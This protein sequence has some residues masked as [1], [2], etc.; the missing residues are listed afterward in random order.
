MSKRNPDNN[1]V[2]QA[3]LDLADAGMGTLSVSQAIAKLSNDQKLRRDLGTR[4]NQ[5]GYAADKVTYTQLTIDFS[6]MGIS[7]AALKVL[8]FLGLYC[9]Q[10]GY[11]SCRQSVIARATKIS[12]KTVWSALQELQK[13]AFIR[14]IMPAARHAPTVWQVDPGV[15]HSGKRLL[16]RSR[17]QAFADAVRDTKPITPPP[18]L[19]PVTSSI[20]RVLPDGAKLYFNSIDLAPP[21]DDTKK[22]ADSQEVDDL[23][24]I[25]D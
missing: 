22:A 7:T 9:T 13:S 16:Q 8:I 2:V 3:L 23:D 17:A 15:M 6:I 21:A 12:A 18:E 19:V 5:R 10:E 20:Y 11:V 14:E 24:K 25:F 4:F 1:A